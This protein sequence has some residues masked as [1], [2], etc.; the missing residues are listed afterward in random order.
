MW[1]WKMTICIAKKLE[2]KKKFSMNEWKAL[3]AVVPLIS[4]SQNLQ[5]MLFLFFFGTQIERC[6]E[7]QQL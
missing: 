3:K 2:E 5:E 1:I 4:R 7:L 6:L